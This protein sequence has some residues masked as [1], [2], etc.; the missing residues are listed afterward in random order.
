MNKTQL[1]HLLY[2][3]APRKFNGRVE[4]LFFV[5]ALA[6]MIIT[7]SLI[8]VPT[9][10]SDETIVGPSIV[11]D[12]N[13]QGNY[14]SIQEAI[15]RADP[16]STI[17]IK[18]GE[19]REIIDINKEITLIGE[20]KNNTIINSFSEQNG[21]AIRLGAENA[22]IR[23]LSIKNRGTGIYTS[24]VQIAASNTMIMDC[25]I[26]DT[27]IGIA[28]WTPNNIVDNCK[29][30]GCSDEGIALLGAIYSE[31]NNNKISN[32]V[33]QENCDGIELQYASRN[34]I[35]NCE[36]YDNTHDGI[37]AIASNNNENTISVCRI[38]NNRVHGIYLSSSS[39]NKII[40]CYISN[41]SNGNVVMNKYSENNEIK[42]NSD[43]NN[44]KL[45][46]NIILDKKYNLLLKRLS[47]LINIKSQFSF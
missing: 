46:K 43:L 47:L 2:R 23:N 18:K 36:L 20:D 32:C 30:R 25:N 34:T 45:T 16:G 35:T 8:F 6:I 41:N 4:Y 14:P 22:K 5:V 7:P 27:P 31:C 17:Y 3:D 40:D 26:Y 28:V 39:N 11:V 38:H 24:A 10:K 29:F 13:G 42:F 21:Y 19:Y 44:E 33:F 37:S 9:A 1:M 12:I 15:N